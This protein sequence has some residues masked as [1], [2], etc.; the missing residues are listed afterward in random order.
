MRGPFPL[1][2]AFPTPSAIAVLRA[3]C[4]ARGDMSQRSL[5]RVAGIS[6]QSC[7]DI[8]DCLERAKL[9]E[10]IR[11]GK[12]RAVRMN[13]NHA[14]ISDLVLPLLNKERELIDGIE[15]SIRREFGALCHKIILKGV[16]RGNGQVEMIVSPESRAQVESLARKAAAGIGERYGL[17]MDFRVYTYA[18]APEEVVFV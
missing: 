11:V 16:M 4:W 7:A 13:E 14:I 15:G 9:V 17:D 18:D 10:R 12:S 2:V 8:L 1:A 6:H 3:L 5:A